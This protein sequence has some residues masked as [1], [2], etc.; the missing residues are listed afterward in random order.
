MIWKE[1]EIDKL[2]R[3]I[4]F[5]ENTSNKGVEDRSISINKNLSLFFNIYIYTLK[6]QSSNQGKEWKMISFDINIPG[7]TKYFDE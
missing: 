4:C 1:K 3:L 7:K 5:L 2:S 6:K